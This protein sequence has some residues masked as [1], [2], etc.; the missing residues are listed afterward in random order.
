MIDSI[1]N[2]ALGGLQKSSQN[3]AKSADNIANPKRQT[4]LV[5]DLIDIRINANYFKTNALVIEKSKEMQE[6]L[7]RAVD[8]EV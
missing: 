5:T 8:I 4:E 2:T 7:F 6:A 3:I 1:L